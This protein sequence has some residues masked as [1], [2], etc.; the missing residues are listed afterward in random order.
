MKSASFYAACFLSVSL[1]ASAA[2]AQEKEAAVP[3]FT[4]STGVFPA[5]AGTVSGGGSVPSSH[6]FVLTAHPNSAGGYGFFY[7]SSNVH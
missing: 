6:T 7:W 1:L 3:A 4:I 2:L 5:G